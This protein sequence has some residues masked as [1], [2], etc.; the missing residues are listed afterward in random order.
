[1]TKEKL[2]EIVLDSGLVSDED[3]VIAA[4]EARRSGQSISNVLIGRGKIPEDY[5]TELLS[6]Y[7]GAP[8]VNLKKEAEAISPDV[9]ELIPEV[10]AKSKNIVLFA[11][12]KE[13]G[14]AKLAMLDPFDYDTIEYV[15]AK[16][17]MWV[18]VYLTTLPSLRYGLKQYKKKV[19]INFDQ[20]ISENVE[21]SLAI[22]G[23]ADVAKSA[24]AVPIVTILDNV[25]DH[26]ASLNAS[27]I[28]F[29]PLEKELLVRFRIDGIMQEIVSLPKAIDP[30]LVARVKILAGMQ[31]DEHRVPQDGRF[32]FDME[33]GGAIDVRVNIM[34]VFS[35]EKVEMRI[36]KGAARPLTL[37]DLGVSDEG[38]SI[39]FNEIKKPHGMIL[40]TGPT[41]HGKTTTLYAILQILNTPSVNIT[42]IEDPVEYE[43]PRVNQT[44]V[45][46]KSGVTFAN[47]LRALLRQNPDIIMIGEIRDNET[48]E[49][50]IHAALTGHLVLSS[51]HTNDA[52]SALPRL[53]DMGAPA[54]L[55]SSTVN[56]V[57]AQ[58]LVRRICASCTESYPASPE[59]IRLIK[60]QME[61]SGHT[62]GAI[63]STLYRGR[64][65][66]VCGNSGFQGQIG[67]YEFF[68]ITD[69][70]RELILRE[71]TVGEVRKKAIE[72]GMTTMF[73]DGLDK[74]ERGVTTIEEI[75]RVVNE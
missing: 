58:R 66:R 55:L 48:V 59:I 7:Y 50:A 42:T 23:E 35:G 75:L 20:I 10:Y 14:R 60:A 9:L 33:D 4:E 26:A 61:L 13:Q 1:M 8:I 32:H 57:I 74:V 15:R 72:D 43:F 51:L 3:F 30:I 12:D 49:I 41:G 69:A 45:N 62:T 25:I 54:F 68:R 47:G 31:I 65:C 52:P 19:G 70:I 39:L 38:V 21:Q 34:P 44:Q 56:L 2:K 28:H 46:I 64:G 63:S 73:Q 6:P 18:D 27:D 67:I 5:F 29:E 36:L 22:T 17:D 71:A 16:L 24:T 40:V 11:Y 53:L 37:K